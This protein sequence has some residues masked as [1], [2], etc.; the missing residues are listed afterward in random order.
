MLK[1]KLQDRFN[2]QSSQSIGQVIRLLCK[3]QSNAP[4]CTTKST[5]YLF[6]FF[7]RF[8]A[9]PMAYGGSQ[10]RGPVG[11]TAAGLHHSHRQHQIR[12]TSVTYTTAHGNARSLTH[13]ARPGIK[14]ASSWILGFVSAEP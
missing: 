11:A 6:F 4:S 9:V 1:G 2:R 3:K 8:R 5:A 7:C 14:P 13:L 12:A 10:A